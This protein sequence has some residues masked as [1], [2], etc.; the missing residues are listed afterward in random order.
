LSQVESQLEKLANDPSPGAGND[1]YIEQDSLSEISI[2]L[3]MQ[4]VKDLYIVALPE[5]ETLLMM[6]IVMLKQQ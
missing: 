5:A 4:Q 1:V 2:A 3:F 6:Q